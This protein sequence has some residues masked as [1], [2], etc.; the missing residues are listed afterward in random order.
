M[1]P[2]DFADMVISINFSSYIFSFPEDEFM[3]YGIS[4]YSQDICVRD[5]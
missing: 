3:Q 5:M 4:I 1:S 2:A